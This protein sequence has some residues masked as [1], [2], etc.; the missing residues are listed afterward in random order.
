MREQ[1][2][3]RF[4]RPERDR[5][6]GRQPS[7]TSNAVTLRDC[8]RDRQVAGVEQQRLG[9]DVADVERRQQLRRAH[10][11]VQRHRRD[12]A[13]QQQVHQK[14]RRPGLEPVRGELAAVEQQQHVVRVVHLLRTTP[15]VAVVPLADPLP[16]QAGQLRGEHRVQVTL[17]VT[18]DRRE[19]PIQGDVGEVVQ[20]GE[21]GSPSRTCSLRS[22]T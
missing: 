17:R 18:A 16:V 12:P 15:P 3:A 5:Y 1:S 14:R 13:L 6:G 10:H 2:G 21:G 9:A 22:G 7:A 19:T 4:A 8:A 20:T 11:P